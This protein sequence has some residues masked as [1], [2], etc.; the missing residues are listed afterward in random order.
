MSASGP[1]PRMTLP[2][3]ILI[4]DPDPATALAL[5]PALRRRGF[6]LH[7]ARDGS[8][9]LQ[10]AILRAPDLVLIDEKAA[11]VD[12][13]AFVRILRANPRTEHIPIVFTGDREDPGRGR[14]GQYLKKP[15]DP[16]EVLARLEQVLRRVEAARAASSDAGLRGSLGQIPLVDLLQILAMN[17]KTG[18]LELERDGARAEIAFV[19]GGFAGAAAGAARGEKALY[20][21][22]AWREGQFAFVAGRAE[23]VDPV[24]KRLEE[25]VLEGLRQCDEAARLLPSV[26]DPGDRFALAVAPAA[27]PEG[28]HPA[29][30]EVV[31]FIARPRTLQEVLDSATA[32]DLEVLRAL[33]ALLECGY[34]RRE[35]RRPSEATS[36][37]ADHEMRGLRRRIE[38]CGGGH[39][40]A[41]G[42]VILAGGGPLARRSAL[43]RFGG[44]P[45]YK[46]QADGAPVD[47]GTLGRL[48]IGERMC[49][50]LVGL[51]TDPALAPLWRPFSNRAVGVLALLP[52][53][54]IAAR[55]G[56]LAHEL[57]CPIGVCGPAEE[58][59]E[60]ALRR[61]PAGCA[62]LGGDPAEALRALL[63]LASRAE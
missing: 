49:V 7:V 17:R 27:I 5:G 12:A 52:T 51:P 54:G 36:L 60:P 44:M 39:A 48:A 43:V 30:A 19:E 37:L 2:R 61:S 4:A 58:S 21:L 63:V 3:K 57:R 8:R 22:L 16:D 14:L 20:R 23:R 33:T 32:T 47:F 25:L 34:A 6:R 55:L 31:S 62:F 40:S 46:A 15:L 56:A 38:R 45:G 35:P 59:V 13:G 26:S 1:D 10:L 42:K 41:A 53:E 11:F 9:A 50:D 18:R 24:R 28:L 29:T